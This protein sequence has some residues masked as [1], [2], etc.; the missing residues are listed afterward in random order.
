[1]LNAY[2]VLKL[3]AFVAG[4]PSAIL[5]GMALIGALTENGWARGVGATLVMLAAPLFIADRLLPKDDPTRARGLVSDVC[6]VSWTFV[7]FLG[8]GLAHGTMGPLLARE[9]DRL[10]AGGHDLWSSVAYVLAGVKVVPAPLPSVPAS[11]SAAASSAPLASGSAAASASA[12]AP[13][14]SAS[15]SAVPSAIA[16]A[17]AAD[18]APS[19]KNEK[20]P[21]ELFK[22]AGPSVVTI[23][24]FQ[25][26]SEGGGTGFLVDKDGTIA[27]NHHVIE[28][29]AR[30]RIKF[31][32]GA[33][34]EDVEIL[35]DASAV[36]LALLK[37]N[38][39]AP[40]DGGARVEVDPLVLG[41][42]EAVVVGE[43]AVSIGNPLGMEHTL[44][45]GLIS[46]RRMFNDRAWIQFS[47][48]ISPGNSGGPLFNMRGEVVGIT[49]AT[50]T[51]AG[52]AQNLNLAVPVNEL[53]KLI[54]PS[55]PG[56]RKLGDGSAPS[57][58]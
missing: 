44:T 28:G 2:R 45:D 30:V 41:D 24:T 48:P 23:F 35:D 51:G 19:P 10:R 47:A 3:A 53:K 22:E 38:L 8:S 29:A 36:D 18:A 21:A 25:K 55:Y 7:V 26:G 42:S 20:T 33:M 9:G 56:R 13:M 58:W 11:S 39:A 6:A 54:R 40:I 31:Q 37:V 15:A 50:V 57:H 1:M 32:S 34:F 16:D 52:R 17:G 14:V 46:S 4:L 27:T 12:S 5:V 43:H 49:T